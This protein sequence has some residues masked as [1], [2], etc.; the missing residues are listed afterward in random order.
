MIKRCDIPETIS[1]AAAWAIASRRPRVFVP[2]DL[3]RE[4]RRRK[5]SEVQRLKADYS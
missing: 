4:L 3:V 1:D 5:A 2:C